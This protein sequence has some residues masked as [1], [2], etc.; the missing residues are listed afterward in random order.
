MGSSRSQHT[1]TPGLLGSSSNSFVVFPA[2]A[3]FIGFPSDSD[4][5][6]AS[7]GSAISLL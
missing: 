6:I 4:H 3:H 7:P 1:L 2:Q 5:T